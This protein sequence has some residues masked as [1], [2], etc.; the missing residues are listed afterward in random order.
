MASAKIKN[1][2]NRSTGVSRAGVSSGKNRTA[3]YRGIRKAFG[4]SAG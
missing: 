4:M 2:I 1:V 3:K